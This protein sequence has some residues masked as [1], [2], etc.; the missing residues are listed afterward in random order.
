MIGV[1]TAIILDKRVERKDGTYAVKLR[2]THNRYQKYYPINEFL[3]V[4]QWEKTLD[5]NSRGQ[6]KKNRIYFTEIEQRAINIIHN[7]NTFSFPAFE[8]KFNKD[9]K[10]QK[11]ALMLMHDYIEKLKEEKRYGSAQSYSDALNSIKK[12]LETQNR[13]RL[14]AWNITPDWLKSYEEWMLKNDRSYTT[15]GIY[16]RS[17]RTI[18]NI[19]IEQGTIDRD[20]Y[21]FSK[22]KYQIPSARNTKKALKLSDIKKIVDYIPVNKY[23]ERAKA[24]WLFCYMCN[25]INVKD[26]AKLRYRNINGNKITFI[27]SKTENTSKQERKTISVP[28]NDEIRKIIDKYGTSSKN[29]DDY[30]F[31]F[32]SIEDSPEE[33]F[34]KIKYATKKI[35]KFMKKIGESLELDLRIT[36]YTARHSFAT[37]LKRSGAPIEFISESLGHKDLKTT[38]N[39]LDSFE[40]EVKEAYQKKLLDF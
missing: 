4:E 10:Q 13:K 31:N 29:P 30:V 8:K 5:A 26:I 7:L 38:E 27:R 40:D 21:P 25:G 11:D 33:Q 3:T 6:Y 9:S 16:L 18:V 22:R 1:T 32:I 17:L 2:I 20:E 24:F 28:I 37:V 34:N 35:N 19:A 14:L 36:T 15:I 23:E 39:Y 12:F